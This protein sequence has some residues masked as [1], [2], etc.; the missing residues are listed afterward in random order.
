M[1]LLWHLFLIIGVLGC[2]AVYANNKTL[3]VFLTLEDPPLLK[4]GNGAHQGILPD[5]FRSLERHTA[6]K[7]KLYPMPYSR[8]M[9]EGHNMKAHLTLFGM[10]AKF[11]GNPFNVAYREGGDQSDAQSI[12]FSSSK[13]SLFSMR[14]GFIGRKSSSLKL[15]DLG[16]YR[17]ASLKMPHLTSVAW[18]DIYGFQPNVDGYLK[19]VHGFKALLAERI[20]YFFYSEPSL[21]AFNRDFPNNKLKFL[22]E[23][24]QIEVKFLIFNNNVESPEALSAVIGDGVRK[25]RESGEIHSI[26]KKHSKLK[27]FIIPQ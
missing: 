15:D 10:P 27:F 8:I 21:Y 1:R 19:A 14:M 24:S 16:R 5:I 12:P 11:E 13:E 6:Y 18:K 20:D 2:Q 25:M 9:I 22:Q 7:F 4:N 26:I 3:K 17:V 23:I